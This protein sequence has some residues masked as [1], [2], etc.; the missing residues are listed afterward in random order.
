MG[1]SHRNDKKTCSLKIKLEPG[2]LERLSECPNGSIGYEECEELKKNH[3]RLDCAY[4]SV[5]IK[6]QLINYKEVCLIYK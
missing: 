5:L 3:E 4:E 2:F 6:S 1:E